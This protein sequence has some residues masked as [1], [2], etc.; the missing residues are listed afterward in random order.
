MPQSVLFIHSLS[1]EEDRENV[2]IS[3]P[4]HPW[5]C[6]AKYK[7]SQSTLIHIYQWLAERPSNEEREVY[8]VN[9]QIMIE[10]IFL[11]NRLYI[12]VYML[13]WLYYQSGTSLLSE[14]RGMKAALRLFRNFNEDHHHGLR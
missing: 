4:V 12:R 10:N 7:S 9:R 3:R 5:K 11:C 6:T 2:I 1:T 13:Y 8:S 14:G